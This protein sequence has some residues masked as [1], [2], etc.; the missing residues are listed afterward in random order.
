MSLRLKDLMRGLSGVSVVTTGPY[1]PDTEELTGL[2]LH[3]SPVDSSGVPVD[4]T[5]PIPVY[6]PLFTTADVTQTRINTATSGDT[7][8]VAGVASQ[9]TRVHSLRLNV[10]GAVIVQV[11][12]GSTI[13]EV[14]NFAGNGGSMVLDLRDRPYY[15]TAANEA[16][17]INLST[18]VQVDGVVEYVTSA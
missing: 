10:A 3:V 12:T 13:R 17:I 4:E 2:A 1:Y 9:T 15:K 8:L 11:K 6:E 14:F 5:N 18:N 7:T 16:F